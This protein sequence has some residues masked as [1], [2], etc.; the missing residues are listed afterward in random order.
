MR[1]E[2]LCLTDI[3]DAAHSLAGFMQ[4]TDFDEFEQNEMMNS[5]CASKIDGHW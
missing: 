1:P 3:V 5:R 4:D 2:K